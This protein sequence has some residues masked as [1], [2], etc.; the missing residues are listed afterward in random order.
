MP[1]I[2]TIATTTK[3]L[4]AEVR[5]KSSPIHGVIGIPTSKRVPGV[6]RK[7]C[8]INNHN[9]NHIQQQPHPTTTT[10]N[11]NHIQQQPHPTTTTS[12]NNH[13]QQQQSHCGVCS[14]TCLLILP[15]L[16]CEIK[17]SKDQDQDQVTALCFVSLVWGEGVTVLGEFQRHYYDDD[18]DMSSRTVGGR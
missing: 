10:S 6:R 9:N 3:Q 12:N 5:R 2:T 11:N 13:I 4:N 16:W 14:S 17:V 8:I 15:Y 1:I 18:D 7:R